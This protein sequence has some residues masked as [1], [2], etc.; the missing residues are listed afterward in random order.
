MLLRLFVY[1]LFEKILR[2][3]SLFVKRTSP[4][5]KRRIAVCS[6]R[7]IHLPLSKAA[8]LVIG[9]CSSK[10]Q[11]TKK[12]AAFPSHAADFFTR[13][14]GAYQSRSITSIHNISSKEG[15]IPQPRRDERTEASVSESERCRRAL[16]GLAPHFTAYNKQRTTRL[17]RGTLTLRAFCSHESS[18]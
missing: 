14:T 16:R 17:R 3:K 10:I 1:N 2:H 5:R 11:Y 13:P 9:K 6:S 12:S 15:S 4:V 8:V 18:C 7:F